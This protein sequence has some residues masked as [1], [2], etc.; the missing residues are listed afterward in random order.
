MKD[1]DQRGPA[2]ARPLTHRDADGHERT[3][4]SWETLTERLIREAQEDGRFDDLPRHGQPL[5]LTDDSHAGELTLA[6]HVLHNAGVA[7]PWIEADKQVRGLR[8]AMEALI[9]RAS[10]APA[11][12]STRLQRELEALADAHDDAVSRLGSLAPS[13]Q[14]HRRPLDR[15][16]LQSRLKDALARSEGTG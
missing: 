15:M 1:M 16:A 10:R 14:Q 12:A 9:S 13:S 5:Q 4:S 2:S 8:H 11:V 3:A 7:P 6:N